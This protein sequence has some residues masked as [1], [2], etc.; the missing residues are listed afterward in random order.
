MKTKN[1]EISLQTSLQRI[2]I[3][4]GLILLIPLVMTQ[5]STEWNWSLSDFVVVAVLLFI[6]GFGI[7]FFMR[8][9]STNMQKAFIGIVIVLGMLWLYVELAVGLFTN[10]GS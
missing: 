1:T 5:V 7:D 6:A 3:G 10:W 4:T 9:K 2:A 8:N